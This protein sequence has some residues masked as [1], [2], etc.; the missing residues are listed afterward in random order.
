MRNPRV[1]AAMAI[2]GLATLT[3]C[4]GEPPQTELEAAQAAIAQ[5]R[6]AEAEKW[7]GDE[8]RAAENSLRA[9]QAEVEAQTQKWVKSYDKARDL[10]AQA[11][12]EAER[13]QSAAVTNKENARVGAKLLWRMPA[14]RWRVP[15]RLSR[16]FP[17][18]LG[19]ACRGWDR[20]LRA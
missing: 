16:T 1:L 9:A 14:L 17:G 18:E 2:L 13:A 6:E 8:L 4:G 5:A 11:Q 15:R 10:L 20:R 3:A 19:Q 12:A 7:A